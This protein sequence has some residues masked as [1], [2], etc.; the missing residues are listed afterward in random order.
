MASGTSRTKRATRIRPSSDRTGARS[1]GLVVTGGTI[2]AEKGNSAISIPSQ[3][4]PNRSA[5]ADLVMASWRGP[6]TLEVHVRRPLRLL[7]EN[8]TPTDWLPIARAVRELAEDKNVSGVLVLHGTDTMAY[9]AAALSFLLS[10]LRIPLV[11]TGSNLPP[12]QSGSD[13]ATNVHDALIAL[14]AL[15]SGTYVVFAGGR[16]L[17]GWVYLGTHLR[18]LRASGQAFT[19]VNRQP[20][21]QVVGNTFVPIDLSRPPRQMGLKPAIDPHV[22]YLRLYPGL[23]LEAI[24]RAVVGRMHGVVVELYASATGPDG[25]DRF[26]LPRFVRQCAQ[27]GIIVVTS[28]A[29]APEGPANVYETTVAIRDAG[30]VFVYDMLPETATTKLMW[31]L[32][33]SRDSR[34]VQRLMLLPVAGEMARGV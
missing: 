16:D 2:G 12:N 17:P 34:S 9:T 31:A 20:V 28:V 26:S 6:T 30:G 29:L 10:D 24:F 13:A 22:L 7:S 4:E 5:D 8:L 21:G 3:N 11:L 25:T 19:S 18:K 15:G 14:S 33:Q 23:D 32:G 27:H 1:I